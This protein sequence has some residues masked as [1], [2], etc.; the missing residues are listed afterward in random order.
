MKI[1]VVSKKQPVSSYPEGVVYYVGR[2][3]PLG[4]PFEIG[5]DGT[6]EEIIAKYKTWLLWQM[7]SDNPFVIMEINN[8][9]KIA[10]MRNVNLQCWCA[11]EACHADVIKHVIEEMSS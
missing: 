5:K 10:N 6:R 4:N 7:N 11:P 3:T 2:P 9:A 1:T 8:I